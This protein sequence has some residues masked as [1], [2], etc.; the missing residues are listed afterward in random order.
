M[1]FC[2]DDVIAER[3]RL[4]SRLGMN[5]ARETWLVHDLQKDNHPWVL[6]LLYFGGDTRWQDLK[7]LE[8]EAQ[9]LQSLH[10]PGIPRYGAAFWS[11]R[12]EGHYFCLLQQY[13][14]GNTLAEQVRQGVRYKNRQLEGL[15][16]AL[17]EILQYLHSQ[18]PPVVHRDLKP[19]NI[20]QG[21]DGAF[22]LIDFG[23]VQA[24]VSGRGTMTVVGTFGYMPP[25]QFAGQAVPAS[26]LYALG[27]TLVHLA[28]GVD[29]AELPRVGLRI[30]FGGRVYLESGWQLWLARLVEPDVAR[31]W[32]SAAEALQGLATRHKLAESQRRFIASAAVETKPSLS[33]W[34]T[35]ALG[36]IQLSLALLSLPVS[37]V[38]F[39]MAFGYPYGGKQ[40]F[41]IFWFV[42]LFLLLSPLAVLQLGGMRVV[43]RKIR[44]F[45]DGH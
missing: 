3:Y 37:F 2:T 36:V 8:R 4:H 38:L 17:L 26:D 33:F 42:M 40:L 11:E 45:L 27:A 19:S 28:S 30:D 10:H 43:Q 15:A 21:E 34:Q 29:P 14:P 9:T 35:I 1:P 44:A 5:G 20:L 25:E 12:P 31:R 16:I 13:I 18:S 39:S 22:Y 41:A 6:K 7:L 32:N 23:A 24:Q